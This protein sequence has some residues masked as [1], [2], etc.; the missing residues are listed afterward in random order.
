MSRADMHVGVQGIGTSKHELQ[1]LA[2][3]GV[4]HM[5]ARVEDTETE[6]LLRHREAAAVEGV[7]LDMI[8]IG[9]PR[10]ITLAQD[11]E[12]DRDIADVCRAIEN[13]GEAGLRG[14]NYNF[15]VGG[16]ARTDRTPGRGGTTYSTFR[17]EEY[18]NESIGEAGHVSREEVFERAGYFLER[19][20]PVAEA[21]R[22]QFAC[23]LNDPPAPILR[24]VE[25][26]NY[27]LFE[28][29][30][31]FSELVE[32]PY[33]GFNFCCGTASEGLEDPGSELY[34]IVRY[35]G[36]CKK[37]F[38]IHFRNIR[39]GLHSFQEVWPDE[40][41]VDMIRLARTLRDAGYPYM[42][43]PDHVP[44][45]PEDRSPEGMS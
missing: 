16:F 6:T 1:F 2:R 14:V 32:S 19:V 44:I 35:F 42:I 13:A 43:M 24:G 41:D 38:N 5:D 9:I 23:H 30:K 22:V 7:S 10:S 33:H 18:D 11:P 40:G 8:H 29:L 36:E 39:G 27:P 4:K 17:L 21:N 37:I 20:I 12:R 3:H 15:Y 25:R 34:D 26:W 45:H 31:R 28:G